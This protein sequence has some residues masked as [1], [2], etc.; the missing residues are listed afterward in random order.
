MVAESLPSVASFRYVEPLPLPKVRG[1]SN[2]NRIVVASFYRFVAFPDF[3]EAKEPLLGR[4]LEC[5]VKGTILLAP[6]GINGTIAGPE[7]GIDAVLECLR[8]DA[9]FAGLKARMSE[10]DGI[11]FGRMRVR[12]KK[13]IVTL[14]AP[15]ADP[16]KRVGEYVA[17]RDW[18]ELLEDPEVVVVDTRNAFEVEEGTFRGAINPGTRSFG[19]FPGW[20]DANL[21][22]KEHRAIAMFC[23]GGIRCEKATS[24]LLQR[25]FERVYHLRGGILGYLDEV[26][27]EESLWEGKCFVFDGRGAIDPL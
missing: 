10:V 15:E 12:L 13:E 5:G 6:E 1:A 11:P 8:S 2:M 4:C 3:R 21:D 9:R 24:Y 23:T 27:A 26:P 22:P 17:P 20:V 19:Q 14:K 7:G 18:N 25:G 16:T